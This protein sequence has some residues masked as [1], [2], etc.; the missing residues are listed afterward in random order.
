[1]KKILFL[2][3]FM[4]PAVMFSQ[5]ESDIDASFNDIMDV[6]EDE[7][8][9]EEGMFTLRFVDTDND[10][11]VNNAVIDIANIGSYTT[12]GRGMVVFPKQKDGIFS[13]SFK[14]D[15]YIPVNLTFEVFAGMIYGNRFPVSKV[16]DL[17]QLRIVLDWGRSPSDLDLHLEKVG[18]YHISY[19]DEKIADDHS[20]TLDRDDINGFGPESITITDLDENAVYNCYVHD[21]SNRNNPKSTKLSKS[22]ARISVYYNN[23]LKSIYSVP[24]NKESG[25]RW[26]VFQLNGGKIIDLNRIAN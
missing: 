26:D 20:A 9:A 24:M 7:M 14:K 10:S 13:F 17:G 1:M 5:V 11:P 6:L 3:V 23:K 18:Q 12:D 22:K 8:S 16:L 25:T 15:G 2:F 19:H 4:F 21:Y